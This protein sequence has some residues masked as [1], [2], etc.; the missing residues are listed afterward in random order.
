MFINTPRACL[1]WCLQET[2]TRSWRNHIDTEAR[3]LEPK[4]VIWKRLT[5]LLWL[6]RV[7]CRSARSERE[8]GSKHEPRVSVLCG[9]VVVTGW[10]RDVWGF[11]PRYNFTL[12]MKKAISRARYWRVIK[13]WRKVLLNCWTWSSSLKPVCLFRKCI[14]RGSTREMKPVGGRATSPSISVA[15]PLCLYPDSYLHIYIHI[16]ADTY[17]Y[18]LI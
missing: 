11:H 3:S 9:H 7:C 1:L 4:P 10:L 18:I 5:T 15:T 14:R 13:I 17:I 6:R 8:D 12:S 16:C 2:G